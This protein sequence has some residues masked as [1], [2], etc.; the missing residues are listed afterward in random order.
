MLRV[1]IQQ[2]GLIVQADKDFMF[3]NSAT[4]NV[5]FQFQ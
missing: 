2:Q 3:E 4:A 5:A 1:H